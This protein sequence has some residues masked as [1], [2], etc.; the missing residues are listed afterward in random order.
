MRG[1]TKHR[2]VV[3]HDVMRRRL[4]ALLITLLVIASGSTALASVVEM[5]AVRNGGPG[6]DR[7][8]GTNG[9]D[10][11]NGRGGNDRLGGHGG[12][13]RLNGGRGND[14]LAGDAGRDVLAGGPGDDQLL[15]GGGSDRLAGGG[16]NDVFFGG[17]GNDSINARDRRGDRISCGP[18]RDRVTS[19]DSFDSVSADCERR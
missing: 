11:I 18:G 3:Q 7:L 12:P 17:A 15:G 16:G 19:R 9:S 6:N 5:A 10:R 2:F 13:D 8:I 4:T 14:L 1:V